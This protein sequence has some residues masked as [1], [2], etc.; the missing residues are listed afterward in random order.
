MASPT[1]I[2]CNRR[3]SKPSRE[4][5]LASWIA[6]E[7][8][9]ATWT[10]RRLHYD[11]PFQATSATVIREIQSRN[12]L[13]MISRKPCVRCNTGWM[14]NLEKAVKPIIVPLMHGRDAIL[15]PAQQLVIT[16]WFVKTVI[17]YEF[18]GDKERG[19]KFF[20][21]SQRHA[22]MRSHLIP[23]YTSIFLARY[24]GSQNIVSRE[25]GLAFA[26]PSDSHAQTP[27]KPDLDGY[28]A[29]FAI[30]HLAL[31]L[32]SI[33]RSE[34]FGRSNIGALL[35]GNWDEA[36]IRIWPL[37]SNVSWPPTADLDD[38]GFD[39]F[40]NRWALLPDAS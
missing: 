18:L 23:D 33:R 12:H 20:Q 11:P 17:M 19:P 1:C 38:A 10:V 7:F 5:V 25:A 39:L 14:N 13:G 22:L 9:H 3:D 36:S 15:T 27:K 4:H 35:Q 31:Q 40:S 30:K 34:K 16:R 21:P 32:V 8:P 26:L 28:S 29:T 2:F 6:G 24:I 37:M